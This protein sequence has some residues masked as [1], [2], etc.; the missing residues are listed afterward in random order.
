MNTFKFLF[1][2]LGLWNCCYHLIHREKHLGVKLHRMDPILHWF[3]FYTVQNL[4]VWP[5]SMPRKN[6]EPW[7]KGYSNWV[8]RK[9]LSRCSGVFPSKVQTNL[10]S[11]LVQF[12]MESKSIQFTP[13]ERVQN[14]SSHASLKT[15][16]AVSWKNLFKRN[17]R[18]SLVTLNWRFSA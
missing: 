2:N 7:L 12:L 14:V 11:K 16:E 17:P 3:G 13:S 18:Q 9:S 4:L 6:F 8:Q 1:Q 5:Q 10:K 15:S